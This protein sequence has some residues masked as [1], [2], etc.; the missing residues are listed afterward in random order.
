MLVD[1]FCHVGRCRSAYFYSPEELYKG[2]RNK[3]SE[4][5]LYDIVP[6]DFHQCLFTKALA[7]HLNPCLNVLG[8]LGNSV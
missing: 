6:N 5:C 7:H 8:K 4:L 1:V 2:H 3:M